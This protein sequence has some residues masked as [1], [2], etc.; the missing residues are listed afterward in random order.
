MRHGLP[1]AAGFEPQGVS[2]GR[3]ALRA[4]SKRW[5]GFAS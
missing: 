1:D 2:G 5:V 4:P 3:A